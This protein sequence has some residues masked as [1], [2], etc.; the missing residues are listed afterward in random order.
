MKDPKTI[1]YLCDGM[2]QGCSKSNCYRYGGQCYKTSNVQHAIEE[3]PGN[4]ILKEYGTGVKFHDLIVLGVITPRDRITIIDDHG[5]HSGAW[6]EDH[7]LKYWDADVVAFQ[8]D[9][10]GTWKIRVKEG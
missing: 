3:H 6:V 9:K 1:F 8:K 2:V 5:F 4:V 10:D 7:I